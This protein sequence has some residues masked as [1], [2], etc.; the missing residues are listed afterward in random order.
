MQKTARYRQV[1]K[2][3]KVQ[4][5]T[6]CFEIHVQYCLTGS[7]CYADTSLPPPT[8]DANPS[9]AP[10]PTLDRLCHRADAL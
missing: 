1:L 5:R 7:E 3:E 6:R 9:S 10:D 8:L 4:V 2:V